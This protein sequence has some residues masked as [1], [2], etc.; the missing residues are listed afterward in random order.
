MPYAKLN[1]IFLSLFFLIQNSYSQKQFNLKVTLDSSINLNAISCF[2]YNGR[3]DVNIRDL[4]VE[5]T[6]LIKGKLY[7][8]YGS[9][10]IQYKTEKSGIFSSSF[11]FGHKK[12]EITFSY[13]PINPDN[14]LMYSATAN[15]IPEYSNTFFNQLKLYR[16]NEAMAVSEFFQRNGNNYY[17]NDSLEKIIGSLYKALNFRTITYLKKHSKNYFSFL[18]F[19][20]QVYYPSLSLFKYDTAYLKDLIEVL[21]NSFPK[22]YVNSYEGRAMLNELDV[23]LHPVKTNTDAPIFSVKDIN[24][25]IINLSEYKGKYV[26]LDFWASWCLP[27]L[28][29]IPLIKQIRNAYSKDKLVIVGISGDRQIEEL[30]KAIQLNEINWMNIFDETKSIRKLYRIRA[31]PVIMLIDNNGKLIY[32]SSEKEDRELLLELLSKM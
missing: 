7:A 8:P 20:T 9:F 25:K 19:R 13:N 14:L 28:K 10:R 17:K 6:L 21:N 31:I 16:L 27:C 26:L 5:N 15:V 22:K 30:R 23:L 1:S 29:Q 2:Y 32:S 18:F 4:F 24:G 3:E 11:L 12:T